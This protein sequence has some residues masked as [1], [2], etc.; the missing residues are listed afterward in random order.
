VPGAV[1]TVDGTKLVSPLAAV[2]TPPAPVCVC[3]A[4]EIVGTKLVYPEVLEV[5]GTAPE[6]MAPG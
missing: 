4:P 5:V 1:P 2:G 6:A 3:V